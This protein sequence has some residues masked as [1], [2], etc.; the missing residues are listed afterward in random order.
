MHS[1]L[2]RCASSITTSRGVPASNPTSW[3]IRWK[4]LREV[5]AG[6]P[7]SAVT[8]SAATRSIVGLDGNAS[9]QVTTRCSPASRSRS[10]FASTV[11]VLPVPAGPWMTPVARLPTR[12]S[13]TRAASW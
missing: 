7:V 3:L 12:S 1:P 9:E 13:T 5:G 4:R 2:S 10:R 6:L 8:S 11:N